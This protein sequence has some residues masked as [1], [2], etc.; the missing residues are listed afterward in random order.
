MEN[1]SKAL[2]IAGSVLVSLMIIA[3]L[4]F[5]FNNISE[6]QS[7]NQNDDELKA[8][9]EFNK[10]YDVYERDIYG[11]ELLSLVNK[12]LDY[13]KR[14]SENKG[15]KKINLIVVLEKDIDNEFFKKGTY[16]YERLMSIVK[17]LENKVQVTGNETIN[18]TIP[19]VSRK[20]SKL[21]T[22]RTADIEN[23]GFTASSY[24]EKVSKYLSYSTL[25]TDVKAKIF[26]CDSFK[27]DNL[28]GRIIEMKYR[29]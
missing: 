2:I 1:A 14:E 23:L 6:L 4:V 25:L 18:S 20:V 27:Y 11:S 26:K 16:N 15:Y 29:F 10:Q 5:F 21:A 22:M 13:N 24:R 12:I 9:S 28:N 19:N 3:L 7:I 8:I 17:D